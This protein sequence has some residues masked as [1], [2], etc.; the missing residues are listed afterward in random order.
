MGS[1]NIERDEAYE[2]DYI[3]V[4]PGWEVQTKGKGS[5]FR[6]CDTTTDPDGDRLAVP[7][8]PYLHDTIERM[9]RATHAEL[10][11]LRASLS[12][13]QAEVERLRG[14]LRAA[15]ED[16]RTVGD[17][18]P[19]SSCCEWCNTRADVAVAALA[20]GSKEEGRGDQ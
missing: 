16:L 2:R 3:S 11:R 19:G 4:A 9:A 10:T 1:D 18:Y 14:A 6:I 5:T 12:A 15:A 13:A 17:D 8:S 7:D 20:G